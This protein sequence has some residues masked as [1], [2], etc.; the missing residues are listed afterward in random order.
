[1]IH[2]PGSYQQGFAPRDF[3]PRFPELW[4]GCDLALAACLGP[5]GAVLRDW[6][7]KQQHCTL[8]NFTLD[9][10]WVVSQG[11]TAINF[12]AS[13]DYIA[14]PYATALGTQWCVSTF[15]NPSSIT[16]STVIAGYR[17]TS[18]VNP[19]VFQLDRNLADYRLIV[20]DDAG[21]GVFLTATSAAV[22]N[23]WQHVF[24]VRNGTFFGLYVNGSLLASTTATLSTIT[25]NNLSIGAT[26]AGSATLNAHWNGQIDDFRLYR[27]LLNESVIQILRLRRGI[28]YE[29]RLPSYLKSQQSNRRRRL[30]TGMV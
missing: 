29:P 16:G 22:A 24:G 21:T 19:I 8:T 26:V 7:G 9:S 12:D 4:R 3:E 25:V 10:A 23:T 27:G 11:R 15:V 2:L 6:S 28:A 1:M 17:S 20:R 14:T 30:L 5:T 18:L 13:N